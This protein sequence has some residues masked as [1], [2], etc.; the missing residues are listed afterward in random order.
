MKKI[1]IS[2]IIL[3]ITLPAQAFFWNKKD[4]ALEAELEGKGYAGTLP[5]LK[6]NTQVKEHKTS[7]PVFE[8]QNDFN[9]PKELKPIPR[10]NPAFIDIIEKKM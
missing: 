5:D 8:S 2:L 3:S 4:K 10:N 6:K 1:L 7:T 9:E